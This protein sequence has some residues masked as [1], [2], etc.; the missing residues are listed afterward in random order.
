[1]IL[2]ILEADG[3]TLVSGGDPVI[4]Q[5]VRFFAVILTALALVPAGAH[6]FELPNKIGLSQE[7][8][9]TVQ[10]VY[11]GWALFGFVLLGAIGANLVHAILIRNEPPAFWLALLAFLLMLASLAIF[12]IW[13]YP[14]NQVTSN[15]TAAPANWASLRTQWEYSHAANAVTTFIALSAVT[16]SLLVTKR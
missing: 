12:F 13:T 15:W 2:W 10:G 4:L 8:Y 11:R 14:A 6:F 7:Q 3:I 5:T 16:A 1:M 9:F